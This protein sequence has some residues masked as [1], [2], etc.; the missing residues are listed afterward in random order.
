MPTALSVSRLKSRRDSREATPVCFS[1]DA[2][3]CRVLSGATTVGSR[4]GRVRVTPDAI[5]RDARDARTRAIA[6]DWN[7]LLSSNVSPVELI[8]RGT[9][10]YLGIFA[11]LRFVLRRISGHVTMA[12]LLMMVLI[13]D[14]AQ[15]AMARD[16]HSVT[17]GAILVGTIVF[18]NFTLDWLAFK[19]PFIGRFVHPQPLPLI[20]NGR[21]LWHNLRKELIS[22]EEL[23]T[24][25][26]EAGVD[27]LARVATARLE[28]DGR[29]SVIKRDAPGA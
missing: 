6:M 23:R 16:Y 27:D 29:I 26:R 20:E 17:D 10:A 25:L 3:G 13:A 18:W 22:M 24:Q 7:A 9:I 12:D 19:V 8:V 15:N 21:I 2:P 5:V 11:L 14:A 28:G 1:T 4:T